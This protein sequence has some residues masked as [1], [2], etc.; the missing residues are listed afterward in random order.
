MQR[1]RSTGTQAELLIRRELRRLKLYF[2]PNVK[3]L[4]GKPDIVFRRK[5]VA[6][7]VDSEFWHCHP[8]RFTMPKSNT[9]YWVCKIAR[10]VSRDERVNAQLKSMGWRVLRLWEQDIYRNPSAATRRILRAIK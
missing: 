1:V 8:N 5:R 10:N 2:A 3:S 6:V 7:F 9:R 4:P